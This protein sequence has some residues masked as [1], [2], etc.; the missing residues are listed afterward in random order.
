MTPDEKM[1][2]RKAFKRLVERIEQLEEDL[3]KTQE[4][5]TAHIEGKNNKKL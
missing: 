2:L 3:A 1:M 5:L 4:Y